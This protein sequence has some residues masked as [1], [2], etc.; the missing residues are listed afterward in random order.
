[1]S[2]VQIGQRAA[3][4]GQRGS[5]RGQ[6]GQPSPLYRASWSTVCGFITFLQTLDIPACQC[7]SN[8]VNRCF[9]SW[10]FRVFCI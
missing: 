6:E 9:I 5:R 10:G 7:D 3:S 8:S 4:E 2:G 1:M